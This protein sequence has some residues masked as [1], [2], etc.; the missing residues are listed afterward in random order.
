MQ[1]EAVDL[2]DIPDLV[3]SGESAGGVVSDTVGATDIQDEAVQLQRIIS[4]CSCQFYYASDGEEMDP[5]VAAE[6]PPDNSEVNI[7]SGNLLSCFILQKVKKMYL[8]ISVAIMS[9]G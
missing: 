5:E 1:Q 6:H 7:F 8:S 2:T 4:R 9:K 3:G